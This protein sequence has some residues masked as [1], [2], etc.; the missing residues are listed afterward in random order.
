MYLCIEEG[1]MNGN[2]KDIRF[3]PGKLY[4]RD[5]LKTA[6]TLFDELGR[7]HQCDGE[8]RHKFIVKPFYLPCGWYKLKSFVK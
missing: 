2:P 1:H 5:E 7:S 4:K 3:K 8:W 6:F